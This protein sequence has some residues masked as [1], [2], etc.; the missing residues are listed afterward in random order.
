[1]EQKNS[2]WHLCGSAAYWS[3]SLMHCR[4][5]YCGVHGLGEGVLKE[6]Q[7]CPPKYASIVGV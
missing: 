3:L 5:G 7:V 4:N 2:P 1:M 6:A